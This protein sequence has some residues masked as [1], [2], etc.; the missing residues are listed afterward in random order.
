VMGV[1]GC[2]LCDG[3]IWTRRQTVNARLFV[4]VRIFDALT[5]ATRYSIIDI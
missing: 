5:V 1:V 2:R 3:R 4:D